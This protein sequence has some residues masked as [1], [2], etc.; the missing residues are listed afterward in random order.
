MGRARGLSGPTVVVLV[1]GFVATAAFG[2]AAHVGHDDAESR[3]A[4]QRAREASAVLGAGV[5]SIAAP[6]TTTAALPGVA[7]AGDA[8]LF[9][10]AL[11]SQ[12]GPSQRFASVSLWP[13][14]GSAPVAVVGAA[15]HL[16][17]DQQ[18]A[19]ALFARAEAKPGTLAVDGRLDEHRLGYAVAS[20]DP[21]AR[22]VV[23]AE[24]DLPAQPAATQ[25]ADSPFV[26]LDYAV[27][28]GSDETAPALLFASTTKLPLGGRRVA[29][30]IPLGDTVLRLVTSPTTDFGGRGLA[31]L[32]WLILGFGSLLTIGG[33][34]MT[35][36]S[37]R[38]RQRA[39]ALA[40]ENRRL[41]DEQRAGAEALQR[42]L[43]PQ[44]R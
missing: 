34:S 32:P 29:S 9:T 30:D 19:A 12:V 42:G 3:L 44:T 26:G 7:V 24:R 15:P 10:A 41:F 13:L 39:V 5:P 25:V 6:L 14:D 18:R 33:A 16:A 43:L 31:D 28:L 20:S 40:I 37:Q 2:Y 23:Y 8:A 21:A 38:R 35:E 11:T 17:G 36:V 4:A 1:I 22:Y 27:Y